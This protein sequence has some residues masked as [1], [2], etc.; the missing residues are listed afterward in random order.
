MKNSQG[1]KNPGSDIVHVVANLRGAAHDFILTRLADEGITDL[2]PS[3]GA[4][5]AVLYERGDQP[6]MAISE[7]IRRDKSTL[8]VLVRKLQSLGYV[9]RAADACDGRVTIV[10]LTEK[11]RELRELFERISGELC[12]EIWCDADDDQKEKLVALLRE[13]TG[14][15]EKANEKHETQEK[16]EKKEAD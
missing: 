14:R 15:L 13:M 2:A 1:K 6:M 11:G 5:L 8:T 4:I 7:Y 12:R 3:H 9:T 16:H 10:R